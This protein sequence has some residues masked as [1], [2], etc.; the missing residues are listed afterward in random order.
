MQ[1][2]ATA[3]SGASREDETMQLRSSGVGRVGASFGS[4]RPVIAYGLV[5]LLVGGLAAGHAFAAPGPGYNLY[6]GD[7][8]THTGYSDG[9]GTPWD[10]YAAAIAAGADFLATTEHDSYGFWLSPEEWQDNLAAAEFY[11]SRSFVAMAGYEY[12]IAGSGE[13][14]VF[15]TR[16][17]P[18][19]PEDPEQ[20][21]SPGSHGNPEDVLPAFYDWLALQPGAVGQ[22]N[23]PTY[24]S[25]EFFGFDFWSEQRDVGMGLIEVWNDSWFYT[26]DSYVKALDAGWHVM[27]AA[28]ADN[29]DANWISGLPQRTV[30]LAK[31]LSPDDLYGAMAAGRGYATVDPNL[32][33][34]YT[35]NDKIM[36]ST[37]SPTA[38]YLASV[39]IEDPDGLAITLV[40]IVTD[41]CEVAA[42][43]AAN[44]PVVEWKPTLA[45]AT[46]RYYYVRVTTESNDAGV[47][48]AHPGDVG[49][50]A[51]TAPV[52]TGR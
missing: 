48:A 19:V 9:V 18:P 6:F 42:S 35:L 23:H 26:E 36:G 47:Q 1:R 13:I 44:A 4:I 33:I 17:F 45:S 10:A 24:V 49:I 5:G 14:N 11:T 7:L 46:A 39:S 51:V 8:H 41:G 22:W 29:H 31:R 2:E 34:Y 25:H 37:L 38:T 12:W 21:P 3:R 43:L 50:T 32:R 28:N 40:E 20:R 27:P 52:W 15:N 16:D 30:L